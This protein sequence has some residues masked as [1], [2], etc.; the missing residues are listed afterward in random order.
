MTSWSIEVSLLACVCIYIYVYIYIYRY[1]YIYNYCI[2]YIHIINTV[3]IYILWL[4]LNFIEIKDSLRS[5]FYRLHLTGEATVK[6]KSHSAK[7]ET[8]WKEFK[9]GLTVLKSFQQQNC[10]ISHVRVFD[11]SDSKLL[12]R[13]ISKRKLRGKMSFNKTIHWPEDIYSAFVSYEK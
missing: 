9:R 12:S 4:F 1:I 6:M 10:Q 7:N 5:N 3:V 11:W 2:L 13:C 8:T